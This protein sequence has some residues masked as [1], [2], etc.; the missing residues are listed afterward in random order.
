MA[1]E[2]GARPAGNRPGTES[3]GID[4]E[5]FERLIEAYCAQR[6]T[7]R[8]ERGLGGDSYHL[9]RNRLVAQIL[10]LNPEGPFD[11]ADNT[12]CLDAWGVGYNAGWK[13][14]YDAAIE[15]RGGGK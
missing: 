7:T 4:F 10:G 13:H 12:C 5:D 3:Q 14:G 11:W 6:I 1:R 9:V 8:K 15:N 2:G